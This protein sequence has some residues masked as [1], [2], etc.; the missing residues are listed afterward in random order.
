MVYRNLAKQTQKG[1]GRVKTACDG[2]DSPA[3]QAM[4]LRR[5]ESS[6]QST[7]L[8]CLLQTTV[9]YIGHEAGSTLILFDWW[10][11]EVN[12]VR[13]GHSN[14]HAFI[15]FRGNIS[16]DD[17]DSQGGNYGI[18]RDGELE[19]SFAYPLD[20]GFPYWNSIPEHKEAVI[21]WNNGR[22]HG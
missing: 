22:V 3:G 10:W 4:L 18:P 15:G 11:W 14:W 2:P 8:P 7:L 21:G 17:L 12:I 13:A 20:A 16:W 9:M 6:G 19:S 1:D 5:L